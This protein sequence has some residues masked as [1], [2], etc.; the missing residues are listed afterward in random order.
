MEKVTLFEQ[1][2]ANDPTTKLLSSP[3]QLWSTINITIK[4]GK[5][6]AYNKYVTPLSVAKQIFKKKY[7]RYIVAKVNDVFYDLTKP[8]EDDCEIEFF[9]MKDD[10]VGRETYWRS[11]A[12]LLAMC[13]SELF[14]CKMDHGRPSTTGFY[15][16]INSDQKLVLEDL[17]KINLQAKSYIAKKL[18]FEKLVVSKGDALKIFEDNPFKLHY[19]NDNTDNNELLT[20][21][22]C[23][24]TLDLFIGADNATFLPHTGYIKEFLCTDIN[25]VY[26]L[27]DCTNICLTRISGV[28]FPDTKMLAD[29]K[30]EKKLAELRDHR[31]IGK[32]QKLFFFHEFSPGSCFFLPH[33][34]RIYNTLVNFIKAEYHKRGFMEVITP[35]MCDVEL[36]KKS[37]HWEHYQ[38][39]M[40]QLSHNDNTEY[41][42][43]PMNCP[44]HILVYNY[45]PKSYRD[46]PLRIADF[47]VLHRKELSGALTGL[48]RVIRFSQD[49][50]HIFVIPDQVETEI[51]SCL[52]F[53]KHVYGI[54]GFTYKLALSTRPDSYI[55]TIDIWDNAESQLKTALDKSG[56]EWKLNPAD[57]AFYG[58]KIDI[59]ISDAMG[60]NHQCATIQLDFN[61]PERFDLT[62]I[63][64][65]GTTARP[66]MIH[67]AILGSVERM[68]AIL[69][70]NYGGKWPFWLSPRQICVIPID[71]EFNAYANEVH[72]IYHNHGFFVEIDLGTEKLNKKIRNAQLEQ[73]NFVFV[74]GERERNAGTVGVRSRESKILGM[75]K[76]DELI[77]KLDK[78]KNEFSS[79]NGFD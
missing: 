25:S 47:G 77:T 49:D 51:N 64:A 59:T 71:P 40:F 28:A 43:C 44:K 48:T 61:L 69:I 50:A 75:F 63:K 10:Q 56:F 2:K 23:G 72:Q 11:S 74:I 42:L 70:E 58:P 46:L 17:E 4:N 24:N 62:F 54:F 19:L 68:I 66:V 8:L 27:N 52:D 79:V 37:G 73:F 32:T 53:I 12:H 1:L 29:W 41:A 78:L 57:G 65:D 15:Y 21:C 3:T 26:W 20:I 45:A 14:Q 67:R 39:N 5:P 6:R 33:G 18:P 38:K 55:G 31:L 60:K 16:D 35:V 13:A 22:Q 9:T 36:W 7:K 34:T 30:T 76:H